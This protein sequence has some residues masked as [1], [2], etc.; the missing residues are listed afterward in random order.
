VLWRHV[1]PTAVLPVLPI[2]SINVAWLLGGVVVVESVFN[3]P[4]LGK[5]MLDSV[6]TR[7]LPVLQAIAVLS[8]L[9]YVV[10]NLIS[11]LIALAVDPRLRTGGRARKIQERKVQE[12]AQ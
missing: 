10:A 9:I 12:V 2:A 8:A 7:D 4:G 6:S 1:S 3:Y 5:L 11:D